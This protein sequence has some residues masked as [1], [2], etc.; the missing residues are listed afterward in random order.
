MTKKARTKRQMVQA[1]E[2]LNKMN[3]ENMEQKQ[4]ALA[5]LNTAV[6]IGNKVFCCI[7][8]KMLKI[9]HAM[10]QRPL[11]KKFKFILDNW[12][13]DQCDPIVVNYRNDGYCIFRIN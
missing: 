13:D 7:P 10:Y 6:E 11:Q 2:R 9:D 4:E 12:D 8:I 1:M 5:F 3:G